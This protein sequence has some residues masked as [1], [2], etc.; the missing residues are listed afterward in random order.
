MVETMRAASAR[1]ARVWSR[2]LRVRM[3][4]QR[5]RTSERKRKMHLDATVCNRKLQ[6]KEGELPGHT[7]RGKVKA[8]GGQ[9]KSS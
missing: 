1:S 7:L 4:F 2:F 5:L 8:W 6:E 9:V 3:G